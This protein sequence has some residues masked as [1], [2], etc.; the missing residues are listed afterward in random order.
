MKIKT[1]ELLHTDETHGQFIKAGFNI[2]TSLKI[3]LASTC[4]DIL[5]QNDDFIS[6]N[7]WLDLKNKKKRKKEFNLL[8]ETVKKSNNNFI[9]NLSLTDVAKILLAKI[10][11]KVDIDVF[12]FDDA[13]LF[14]K[15]LNRQYLDFF[16]MHSAFSRF[17]K[18]VLDLRDKDFLLDTF[19]IAKNPYASQGNITSLYA[20]GPSED[21]Q[22][23]DKHD[24]LNKII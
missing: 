17:F 6:F 3:Y 5:G 16:G 7:S 20:L 22:K 19:W 4:F 8:K 11:G 10:S 15:T 2:E 12:K 23:I 18:N 1:V 24:K 21:W 13:K 9:K 14:T